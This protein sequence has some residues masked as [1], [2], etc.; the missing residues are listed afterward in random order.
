MAEAYLG[1]CR[2]VA[3]GIKGHSPAI[4]GLGLERGPKGRVADAGNGGHCTTTVGD[5]G[6]YRKK[7]IGRRG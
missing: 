1:L 3:G 5:E 7:E 6:G 4:E 2:V